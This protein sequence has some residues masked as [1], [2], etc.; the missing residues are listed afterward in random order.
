MSG[1]E[2][3]K[4]EK[5]TSE[6]LLNEIEKREKNL[7]IEES[8]LRESSRRKVLRELR[9]QLKQNIPYGPDSA[10]RKALMWKKI[11]ED[12]YYKVMSRVAFFYMREGDKKNRIYAIYNGIEMNLT[13]DIERLIADKLMD[14]GINSTTRIRQEIIGHI[15]LLSTLRRDLV[16]LLKPYLVTLNGYVIDAKTG[17]VLKVTYKNIMKFY[18]R[19]EE[20]LNPDP[21]EPNPRYANILQELESAL[22]KG[23]I[24]PDE[25]LSDWEDAV[26]L[27]HRIISVLPFPTR[28]P[29]NYNPEAK[30]PRWEQFINEV[31]DKEYHTAIKRFCG[32]ILYPDII[33]S[34]PSIALFVGDGANGK[35]IFIHT[36]TAVL[37]DNNVSSLSIQEFNSRFALGSV[38]DKLLNTSADLPKD[39]IRDAGTIK[40]VSGGDR[41]SVERKFQERVDTYLTAKHIYAANELPKTKDKTTGFYRRFLFFPFPYQ[42]LKDKADPLLP[43]KLYEEREGILNWMLEGLHELLETY[44]FE[45]PLNIGET[46]DIYEYASDSLK[47]FVSVALAD[48]D[49]LDELITSGK[50]DI[51][52]LTKE[53]LKPVEMTPTDLYNYYVMYCHEKHYSPVGMPIFSR[54]LFINAPYIKRGRSHGER[55]YYNFVLLYKPSD[56]V[57]KEILKERLPKHED[58]HKNVKKISE[59]TEGDE[60]TQEEQEKR[61]RVLFKD[62]LREEDLP[63]SEALRLKE[64]GKVEI[65]EERL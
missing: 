15:K 3:E 21:E 34:L 30:A 40:K 27:W 64:A 26:R 12:F 53:D 65:R 62:S 32:Y 2:N 54:D 6:W 20:F 49:K 18:Q 59:F 11:A 28:L 19:F 1:E 55:Y 17:E 16:N 51:S 5:Y 33:S 7:T 25:D 63:I 4:Y 29:V 37:G 50:I 47:R 44:D 45:H 46:I 56:E 31:L 48:P 23:D 57:T 39:I 10:Y 60:G 43:Q 52:G 41:L 42:F 35:T 13:N 38:L 14:L 24:K 58:I 22:E 8:I 36:L 61:V 9:T